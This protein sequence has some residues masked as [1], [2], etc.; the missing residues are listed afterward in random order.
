[1]KVTNGTLKLAANE[2]RL[3]NFVVKLEKDHV[4]LFD[5]N[6][7][8]THRADRR[9]PVGQFLEMA[10]RDMKKSE[11]LQRGIG[12]WFAVLFTV[13][14]VVPDMEFM[15]EVYKASEACMKRHPEAYGASAEQPT[16]EEDAEIIREVK[17]MKEFEEDVRNM[18]EED[19]NAG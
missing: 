14:S 18:P 5:I 16:D 1:M 13:F 12:N 3:G 4:K 2:K 19:D 15:E 6:S 10:Y 17:E 9:T 8:F 7:V 11:E